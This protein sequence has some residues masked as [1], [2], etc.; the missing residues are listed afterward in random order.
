[1]LNEEQNPEEAV[2]QLPLLAAA[3]LQ[4]SLMVASNDLERL[5]RLLDDASEALL[6]V[7]RC[8]GCSSSVSPSSSDSS[9]SAS[10]TSC[11]RLDGFFLLDEDDDDDDD[12]EDAPWPR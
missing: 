4:D 5:Q 12:E 7:T 11:L 6:L 1:M 8:D 10:S 9:V 2:A 3:D